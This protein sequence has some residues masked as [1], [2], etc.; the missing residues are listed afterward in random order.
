M[1][2]KCKERE[3]EQRVKLSVGRYS[4]PKRKNVWNK[5][6]FL[7]INDSFSISFHLRY[8]H[9]I[10]RHEY[11]PT[12]PRRPKHSQNFSNMSVK[13]P[14]ASRSLVHICLDLNYF[15]KLWNYPRNDW[16]W[17]FTFK[18]DVSDWQ[19]DNVMYTDFQ[20]K[21]LEGCVNLRLL[22]LVWDVRVPVDGKIIIGKEIL[23]TTAFQW[24]HCAI[25]NIT[26]SG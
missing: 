3:T 7:H 14:T 22:R 8:E 1:N 6:L 10:E 18:L 15:C 12:Q 26:N 2:D 13:K 23:S 5:I 9:D 24:K 19:L 4:P 11:F 16:W 17:C 21:R 25:Y 20:W